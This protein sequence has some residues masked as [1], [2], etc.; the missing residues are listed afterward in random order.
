MSAA[1]PAKKAKVLKQACLFGAVGSSGATAVLSRMATSSNAAAATAVTFA[2]IG[3]AMLFS[4]PSC[5][6]NHEKT[7]L[8]A[9]AAKSAQLAAH[10]MN[11]NS[12]PSAEEHNTAN[13]D[14]AC[15][16]LAALVAHGS[17]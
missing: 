11:V 7:C 4:R 16:G 9:I 8:A 15:G 14:A 13:S 10:C 1:P 2:C 5:K 6:V 3:C 17:I 12:A